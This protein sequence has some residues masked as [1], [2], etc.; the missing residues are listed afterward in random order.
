M[1]GQVELEQPED[2]L[3]EPAQAAI[4]AVD[5]GRQPWLGPLAA[6]S[7]TVGVLRHL[8]GQQEI[9]NKRTDD[10]LST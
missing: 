10:A 2:V 7:S 5:Q 6:S 3:D 1:A 9:A 4:G 8:D